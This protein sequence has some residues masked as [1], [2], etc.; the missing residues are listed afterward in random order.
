MTEKTFISKDVT[1][2]PGLLSTVEWK[3]AS[4]YREDFAPTKNVEDVLRDLMQNDGD[5]RQFAAYDSE[6]VPNLVGMVRLVLPP[7]IEIAKHF[8]L[9]AVPLDRTGEIARL[10][11]LPEYRHYTKKIFDT[12]WKSLTDAAS[13]NEQVDNLVAIMPE[14]VNQTVNRLITP[15][16]S[17]AEA[18]LIEDGPGTSIRN[19]YPGY[20]SQNPRPYLF[21]D[22]HPRKCL[23][24]N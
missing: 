22:F 13:E 23:L 16:V 3:T 10:T 5:F 17:I 8:D 15:T 11:V 9:G 18:K 14:W 7:T 1:H 12:L 2:R 4:I 24:Q 19:E 20:W 21:T 6:I